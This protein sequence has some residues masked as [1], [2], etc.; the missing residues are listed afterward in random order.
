MSLPRPYL[1]RTT[2]L[3]T[4]RTLER[5]FFLNPDPQT[6]RT[7]LFVLGLYA[8]KHGIKVHAF[9]FM[10]NHVHLVVTD[11]RGNLP[12]FT[13]DLYSNVARVMN[14]KMRRNEIFWASGT[15]GATA[16]IGDQTIIE[17]IA[18]V[19]TNPV[20][21]GVVPTHTRWKLN[22]THSKIPLVSTLGAI[23]RRKCKRFSRPKSYFK[24][25][26]SAVADHG[27]LVLEPPPT[28]DEEK[29]HRELEYSVKQ[30]EKELQDR[31]K[32]SNHPFLGMKNALKTNPQ[33]I[34]P[35]KAKNSQINP[36]L[37][38]SDPI[39]LIKEKIILKQ[40]RYAHKECR[41]EVQTGKRVVIFPEGTYSMLR[42]YSVKIAPLEIV[43]R[44]LNTG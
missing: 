11:M 41:N 10:S 12:D 22:Q 24:S 28:I 3:L 6:A 27:I 16:L 39:R 31:K 33:Y 20:A 35:K 44:K 40:F 34:P 32:N 25:K 38:C 18:Y 19:I 30:R 9:V 29:F 13:R 43:L 42:L 8:K 15:G 36:L 37:A 4:R 5:R 7:F 21:A 23:N 17:K 1:A 2:Y 26:G 14:K